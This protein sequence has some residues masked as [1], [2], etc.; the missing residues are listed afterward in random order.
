MY[1]E[2]IWD[3]DDISEFSVRC[4]NSGLNARFEH[5]L[6]NRLVAV[7]GHFFEETRR[8]AVI[9]QEGEGGWESG[10]GGEVTRGPDARAP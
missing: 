3:C 6:P 7:N 2:G 5:C 10:H 9:G 8:I 4:L 1:V